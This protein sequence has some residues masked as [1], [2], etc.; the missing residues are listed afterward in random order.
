LGDDLN[1]NILS[2]FLENKNKYS[3]SKQISFTN[4]IASAA[5]S[6]KYLT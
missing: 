1:R 4:L 6:F 2:F 5:K 3:P